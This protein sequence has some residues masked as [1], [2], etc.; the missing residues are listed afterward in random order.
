[1]ESSPFKD[2]LYR[3]DR[4]NTFD[5]MMRIIDFKRG[6]PYVFRM[7]DWEELRDS[8]MCW[9]RTFDARVDAEIIEKLKRE[10]GKKE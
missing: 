5:S 1:M 10:Y 7:S 3:P 4:E 6:D 2:R 8:P 9:A